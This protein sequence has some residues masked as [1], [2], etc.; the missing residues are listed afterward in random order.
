MNRHPEACVW[1]IADSGEISNS[2]HTG[3]QQTAS[4]SRQSEQNGLS[5]GKGSRSCAAAMVSESASP[6]VVVVKTG[7]RFA[8]WSRCRLRHPFT[9]EKPY[10]RAPGADLKSHVTHRVV[11]ASGPRRVARFFSLRNGPN[12]VQ[13]IRHFDRDS[14]VPLSAYEGETVGW[15]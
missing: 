13:P 3:S 15:S 2:P 1:R 8:G 11:A 12:S 5:P 6:A 14:A 10:L 9:S 7:R 4:P